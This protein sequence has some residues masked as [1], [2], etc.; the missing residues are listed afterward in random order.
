MQIRRTTAAIALA[1]IIILGGFN[2]YQ[3]HVIKVQRQIIIELYYGNVALL[4]YAQQVQQALR[5]CLLGD[6]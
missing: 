5:A 2:A 4:Q 1:T 3:A 6:K